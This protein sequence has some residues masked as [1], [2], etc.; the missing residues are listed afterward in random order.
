MHG[1]SRWNRPDR[2]YKP[3]IQLINPN[4]VCM[5]DFNDALDVAKV[6]QLKTGTIVKQMGRSQE[7]EGQD[8]YTDDIILPA[9]P[10][11]RPEDRVPD[12][13]FKPGSKRGTRALRR[14]ISGARYGG[15]AELGAWCHMTFK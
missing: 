10:L 14:P 12:N 8:Q 1:F 6:T 13:K 5:T 4:L 2:F 7:D 3:G 15:F 11:I 9:S